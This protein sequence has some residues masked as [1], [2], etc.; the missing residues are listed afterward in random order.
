M[1]CRYSEIEAFYPE[2]KTHGGALDA[3]SEIFARLFNE[4]VG[5]RGLEVGANKEPLAVA[6]GSL[7]YSIVGVDLRPYDPYEDDRF[8][9]PKFSFLQG[10]FL[11][12]TI[13]PPFDFVYC[14]ST[15][16]HIGLGAYGEEIVPG[17]DAMAVSKMHSLLRPNGR[18][19][20]TIPVGRNEVDLRGWRVYDELAIRGRIL[21]CGGLSSG[22]FKICSETY[23]AADLFNG[24]SRG[25]L[26][27]REEA[28][29]NRGPAASALLVLR[30]A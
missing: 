23:V 7:G 28:F 9:I 25:E 14:I 20:I 10:D 2:F 8:Y 17:G 15:L 24:H 13:G 27:S 12:L 26:I 11:K 22:G 18:A 30:K 29:D 5:A 1:V 4:P 3:D 16:E 21:G 6:L 19:Y